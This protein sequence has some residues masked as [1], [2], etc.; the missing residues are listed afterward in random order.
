MS[1]KLVEQDP[2]EP[3]FLCRL[4]ER[5]DICRLASRVR[6][7]N[8]RIACEAASGKDQ[9]RGRQQH[10]NCVHQRSSNMY[11]LYPQAQQESPRE[12]YKSTGRVFLQYALRPEPL[13]VLLQNLRQTWIEII[14]CHDPRFDTNKREKLE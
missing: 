14:F 1:R 6:K 2:I 11:F 3:G 9:V 12:K 5:V 8:L 10:A 7:S 4:G 13:S